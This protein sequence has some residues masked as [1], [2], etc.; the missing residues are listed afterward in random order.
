MF[1]W[2]TFG[3]IFGGNDLGLIHKNHDIAQHSLSISLH[4]S[5]FTSLQPSPTNFF[6][7]SLIMVCF[8]HYCLSIWM[9]FQ[10]TFVK[11]FVQWSSNMKLVMHACV[12]SSIKIMMMMNGLQCKLYMCLGINLMKIDITMDVLESV[13]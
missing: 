1:F 6:V 7:I 8:I 4:I 3:S 9:L 5:Y 10:S 11:L 2:I 12:W 13:A